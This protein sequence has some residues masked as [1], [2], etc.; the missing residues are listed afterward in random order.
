LI[1]IPNRIFILTCF[2]IFFFTAA[3]FAYLQGIYYL[4]IPP[5]LIV[6]LFLIQNPRYLLYLLVISIPWSFEFSFSP[7]L[8]TDLPDEPMMILGS[9]AALIYLVHNRKAFQIK[10]IH[11][12]STIIIL[13]FAWTLITVIASTDFILS[14]KYLLAKAWYVL[15]FFVLPVI[16]FRDVRFFRKAMFLFL[17]SMLVLT[18]VILFKHAGNDLSFEKVNDSVRPFFKNH[19]SYSSLLVFMVPLLLAVICLA[20]SKKLKWVFYLLLIATVTAVYLS[21]AR[22]AW[23]AL[24]GGVVAYWLVHKRLLLSGFVLILLVVVIGTFWVKSDERLINFSN[25]YKSTIYHSN[26]KEHIIA[27]YKLKDLSNAERIYRWV[28]GARMVKDNWLT[29]WGPSTFYSQYK[30]YTLPAFKT[31]VSNNPE[32]STVHNYFLLMLI[33]QGIIGCFLF[34]MLMTTAFYYVQKIYFGTNERFWKVVSASIGSILVMQCVINFLSDMIE[35]DK[36]GSVFYLCLATLVIA[37]R[38]TQ[39][40][41]SDLSADVERIS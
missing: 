40:K 20:D 8:A 35:T 37:D 14:M 36:V 23:L 1:S 29:G 4:L 18:T 33:E 22:G 30:S 31:Y 21:Y 5:G 34:I 12:L 13:Q 27:T 32:K 6:V 28:A 17:C 38:I 24:L 9:V 11:L 25:D 3:W 39:R 7:T 41:K 26:L 16:L 10:R 2:A 19:V 15:A